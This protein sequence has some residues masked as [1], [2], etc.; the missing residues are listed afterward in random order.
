MDKIT[1]FQN[2]PKVSVSYCT[3]ALSDKYEVFFIDNKVPYLNLQEVY[4]YFRLPQEK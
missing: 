1:T 4:N 3:K 2:Q